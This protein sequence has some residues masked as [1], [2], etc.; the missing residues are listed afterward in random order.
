MLKEIY[1][2]WQGILTTV[3][4]DTELQV[5]EFGPKSAQAFQ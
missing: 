5:F 1:R 3:A 2:Y 4:A